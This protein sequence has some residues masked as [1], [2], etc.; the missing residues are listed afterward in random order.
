MLEFRVFYH[1]HQVF[2]EMLERAFVCDYGQLTYD[3]R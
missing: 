1:A 3:G 2:D